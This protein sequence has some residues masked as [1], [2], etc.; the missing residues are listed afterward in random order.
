M[1]VCMGWY[2]Y[3]YAVSEADLFY[4][5]TSLEHPRGLRR[6]QFEGEASV[7]V[8]REL[9]HDRQ[10]QETRIV[11]VEGEGGGRGTKGC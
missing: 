5:R 4:S 10:R 3:I 11:C 1:Y 9:L 2:I 8:R 7:G 6:A